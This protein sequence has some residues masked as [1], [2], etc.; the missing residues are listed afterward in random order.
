MSKYRPRCPI[1][2]VTRSE[3]VGRQAHLHRGCYPLVYNTPMP[4]D[5]EWQDDVDGRIEWA[6]VKAKEMGLV[7]SGQLV[8]AIQGWKSG[9]G[10]TN[11]MRLLTVHK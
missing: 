10:H 6:L 8:I 5:S 1:L 3:V 4:S 11:T 7:R 9:E 2:S